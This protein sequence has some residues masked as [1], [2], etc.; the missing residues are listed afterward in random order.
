MGLITLQGEILEREREQI[1]DLGVEPHGRQ[2]IRLAAQLQVGLLDVVGI[3][4]AVAAGPDELAG[5]QVADLRHHQ[6]QQRVAGDIEGH[7]EKTLTP[8]LL[9]TTLTCNTF[10]ATW[11]MCII[12][13]AHSQHNPLYWVNNQLSN[14]LP[15]K[16]PK[17]RACS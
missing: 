16:T 3:Q 13:F 15:L 17:Y 5:L 10:Q 11:H 6:C 7:A 14:A 12:A 9:N 8:I 4:V 2:R 1:L